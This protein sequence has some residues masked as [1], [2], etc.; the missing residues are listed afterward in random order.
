MTGKAEL[1]SSKEVSIV[2]WDG[3]KQ[4][5]EPNR[6]PSILPAKECKNT[7]EEFE[8]QYQ[9]IFKIYEKLTSDVEDRCKS[10]LASKEPKEILSQ[11]S[12]RTKSLKSARDKAQILVQ[13]LGN[14]RQQIEDPS[15]MEQFRKKMRDLAGVRIL[16]Y[17][18]D[19]VAEVVQK[20]RDSGILEIRDVELS[21]SKNRKDGR[22]KKKPSV[23]NGKDL[24]YT[25]G[26]WIEESVS[27]GHDVQRWKNY[28]YKAVHLYVELK[29]PGKTQREALH[30]TGTPSSSRIKET[31]IETAGDEG[32][33][34]INTCYALSRDKPL[35]IGQSSHMDAGFVDPK[36]L[37]IKV[38][39]IQITTVVMHAWSQV[40]HDIIFKNPLNIP[41]V[42]TITRMLDGINGLLITSEIM[43]EELHRTVDRTL[44]TEEKP[45]ESAHE[46]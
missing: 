45:F 35:D 30:L 42:P 39:Q 27:T 17:F 33:Q 4:S 20:I 28:G 18:P 44:Q 10:I 46:L 24:N 16:T 31:Q 11:I 32:T 5:A 26:P 8:D 41:T 38:A 9:K 34:D 23:G 1:K 36:S 14:S 43:L 2:P 7:V 15:T 19:D 40:E 12:S 21:Y 6:D 22:E 37:D 13:I 29:E 25:Y 3:L